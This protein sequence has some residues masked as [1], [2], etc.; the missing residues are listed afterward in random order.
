MATKLTL[1]LLVPLFAATGCEK[2]VVAE[3]IDVVNRQQT[4]AEKRESKLENVKEGLTMKEVEAVLGSPEEVR[5]GKVTRMVEKEFDFTTWTYRE[6]DQ[7]IEVSFIDGKLQGQV[8]KF[9]E[10]LNPVAPLQMK[11]GQNGN[12]VKPAPEAR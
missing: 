10:K 8:P 5:A 3:N 4:V 7:T 11:N 2:H 1:F 12:H 6:G 9:G